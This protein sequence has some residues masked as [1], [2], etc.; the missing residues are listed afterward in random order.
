MHYLI[1]EFIMI[2]M[3]YTKY[4]IL[5][6]HKKKS[7]STKII[8]ILFIKSITSNNGFKY[9]CNSFNWVTMSGGIAV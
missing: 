9:Q 8:R 1:D 3:P 7:K 5:H 4:K 2:I 6:T